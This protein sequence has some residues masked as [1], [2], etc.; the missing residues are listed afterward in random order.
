MV[1]GRG[2]IHGQATTHLVIDPGG[3]EDQV[4]MFGEKYRAWTIELWLAEDDGRLVRGIFG[5]P[6]APL[7]YSVPQ[8]T[9]DIT[10][11]DCECPVHDPS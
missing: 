8:L 4:Q 9:V 11:V 1:L 3:V 2:T 5:G 6:Q 10:S 7:S